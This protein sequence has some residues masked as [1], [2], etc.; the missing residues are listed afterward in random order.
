[1]VSLKNRLKASKPWKG[2]RSD[3]KGIINNYPLLKNPPRATRASLRR[4][5]MILIKTIDS[6]ISL[7]DTTT[8][9]S[10]DLGELSSAVSDLQGAVEELEGSVSGLSGQLSQLQDA[11]EDLEERVEALENPPGGGG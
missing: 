1:M 6:V 8:S 4:S 9:I 10:G 11:L 2:I 5:W 7:E 3:F